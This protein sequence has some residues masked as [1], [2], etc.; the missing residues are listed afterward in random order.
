MTNITTFAAN[1]T[2]PGGYVVTINAAS[3]YWMASGLLIL[4]FLCFFLANMQE[5]K[6]KVFL[7]GTTLTFFFSALFW[8]AHWV[9][10]F[11]VEFWF[12]LFVLSLVYHAMTD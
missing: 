9:S 2:D 6:K 8:F 10:F 11:F 4:F 1:V 12:G 7:A 5:E 3:D